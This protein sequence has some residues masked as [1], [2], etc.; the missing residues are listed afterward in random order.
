MFIVYRE[1][2]QSEFGF[3]DLGF[4]KK[5]NTAMVNINPYFYFPLLQRGTEG[6]LKTLSNPS[7]PPFEKGRREKC[8]LCNETSTPLSRPL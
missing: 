6:D 4:L 8:N 7:R 2:E 1:R 3:V 5:L